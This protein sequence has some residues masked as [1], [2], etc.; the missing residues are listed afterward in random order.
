[1]HNTLQIIGFSVAGL[2]AAWLLVT[3]AAFLVDTRQHM[4]HVSPRA[5]VW[6]H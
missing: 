6:P 4:A 3:V 5:G 1:M 2:G